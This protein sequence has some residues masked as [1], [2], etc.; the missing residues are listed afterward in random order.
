MTERTKPFADLLVAVNDG[1][2]RTPGQWTPKACAVWRNVSARDSRLL[3]ALVAWELVQGRRVQPSDED[4]VRQRLQQMER[5]T[6]E[7]RAVKAAD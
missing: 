2:S 4:E 6:A 5:V 1:N 7:V 3:E